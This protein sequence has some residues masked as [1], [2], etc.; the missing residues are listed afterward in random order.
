MRQDIGSDINLNAPLMGKG[1]A[2]LDLFVSKI[3]CLGSEA[4]GLTAQIYGIGTIDDCCF[5]YIQAACRN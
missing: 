1:N 2:F 5:Q 3:L 4:E